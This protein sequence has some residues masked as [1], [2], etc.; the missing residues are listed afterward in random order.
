M[1]HSRQMRHKDWMKEDSSATARHTSPAP[2]YIAR[3]GPYQMTLIVS[4]LYARAS[5]RY[6]P[7]NPDFLAIKAVFNST[8]RRPVKH[9]CANERRLVIFQYYWMMRG[10][11]AVAMATM[12]AVMS[13]ITPKSSPRLFSETPP[14]TIMPRSASTM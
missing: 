4:L 11:S 9:T 2:S 1:G 5:V 13:S 7:A 12:I 14:A 3:V 6:Y 8:R 10:Y